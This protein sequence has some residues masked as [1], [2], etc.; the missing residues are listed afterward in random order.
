[1]CFGSDF[2]SGTSKKAPAKPKVDFFLA[3]FSPQGN[4]LWLTSTL[5][6][7]FRSF[8]AQ[9][10]SVHTSIWSILFPR[11][12]WIITL[13]RFVD[14]NRDCELGALTPDWAEKLLSLPRI[15]FCHGQYQE[16]NDLCVYVCVCVCSLFIVGSENRE[17]ERLYIF[18]SPLNFTLLFCLMTR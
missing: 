6:E 8:T 11:G 3:L 1:M 5:M 7:S 10:T 15:M 12:L 17:T 2:Q 4:Y 16:P 9:I 18:Q 14:V 13:Q